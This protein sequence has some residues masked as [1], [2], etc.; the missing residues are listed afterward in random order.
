MA[1]SAFQRL[2]GHFEDKSQAPARRAPARTMM[3]PPSVFADTW[4]GKPDEAIRLGIVFIAEEA[5]TRAAAMAQQ[6]AEGEFPNGPE[7]SAIDA[8]NTHLMA[9]TLCRV[10]CDE[11]DVSRLFFEDAPEM[12]IRVAMTDRG[13][14]RVWES[15]QR[16][17]TEES[18]LSDEATDAEI[19]QLGR[20][21][22]DGAVSRLTPEWQRRM[23]R[24]FGEVAI[25]LSEAPVI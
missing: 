25:E 19:A 2:V 17:L 24:L 6:S 7:Q 12:A 13:I 1:S 9:N 18:P 21:L 15:Y 5:Q 4:Q 8:F 22:A 3:V 10:L 23:R 11:D 14:A 16:I 20:L